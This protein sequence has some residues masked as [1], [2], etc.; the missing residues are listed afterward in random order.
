M[1]KEKLLDELYEDLKKGDLTDKT[2]I[3]KVELGD[4]D[5]IK[6]FL[7]KSKKLPHRYS[8]ISGENPRAKKKT[9]YPLE[10]HLKE[11]GYKYQK[12]KGKYG[13]QTEK[14]Y[15]VHNADPEHINH[16]GKLHGQESV[17]HSE[18]GKHKMVYT[19]GDN[20]GKHHK[21]EGHQVF[22]KE[23]KDNYS[24][25]NGKHFTLNFDFDKLHE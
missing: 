3:T 15:L 1:D 17:I 14:S 19:T 23:P 5:F 9:M 18:G 10:S 8:I 11:G 25:L 16:L 7:E 2:V 22:D 20:A 6:S 13:G 21:G 12:M 24:S 4:E